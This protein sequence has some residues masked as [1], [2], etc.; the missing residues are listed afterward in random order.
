MADK[1]PITVIGAYARDYETSK[2][3]ML[4]W[5]AG[6]DFYITTPGYPGYINREDAERYGVPENI[7]RFRFK[8]RQELLILK[9]VDGKWEKDLDTTKEPKEVIDG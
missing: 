3:V 4:A 5:M 2:E 7:I 8:G 6:K 1:L 9:L